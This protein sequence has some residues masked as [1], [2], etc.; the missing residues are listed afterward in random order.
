MVTTTPQV[1]STAAD[2]T[3]MVALIDDRLLPLCRYEGFVPGEGIYRLGEEGHVTE[4]EFLHAF[5]DQPDWARLAY[6]TVG[7][8]VA[9]DDVFRAYTRNP[10]GFEEWF[11]DTFS[12][13]N[14]YVFYTE[15]SEDGGC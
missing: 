4:T 9:P 14:E 10:D 15:A 2:I 11:A 12:R 1:P 8:G 3:N 13:F 6:I 5:A 7:N